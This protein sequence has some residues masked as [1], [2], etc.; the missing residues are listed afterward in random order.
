MRLYFKDIAT[1]MS[2]IYDN[3]DRCSLPAEHGTSASF[4]FK[5]V[6][7]SEAYPTKALEKDPNLQLLLQACSQSGSA[8]SL[9]GM[10]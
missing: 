8:K 10:R 7:F 5:N 2:K 1:G 3:G 6:A 4:L 9:L